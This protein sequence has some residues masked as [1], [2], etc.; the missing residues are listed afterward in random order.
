MKDNEHSVKLL[1]LLSIVLVIGFSAT[2]WISYRVSHQALRRQIIENELPLTSDNIYSEIQRDLLPPVFI[3]SLM[4]NDSFL[5]NWVISGEKNPEQL[6]QFLAETQRKYNTFTCFLVSERTRLYYQSKGILKKVT[7]DNLQDHWYFRVRKMKTDHEINIDPD[8]ANAYT[9]TIFV[10]NRVYDFDGNYIGATGVGLKVSDVKSIIENYHKKFNRIIHFISREGNI[11]LSTDGNT[12]RNI[13]DIPGLATVAPGILGNRADSFEYELDGKTFYVKTRFIPE[14]NWTLLV[15]K[16]DEH[17]LRDVFHS[18]LLNL[19]LCGLVTAIVTGL[20]YLI[21]KSHRRKLKAMLTVE[22]ELK[23]RNLEQQNE[24]DKQHRQLIEQNARLIQLNASKDKLFSIIAH[25]LRSPLGNLSQ[26]AA[27]AGEDLA[28]GDAKEA[29]VLLKHQRELADSTLKLLDHLFDWARS[30]MSEI[31]CD[32]TDFPLFECLREG[33][34]AIGL[35]AD[36]KNIAIELECAPGITVN[37]DRNMVMTVIRN[38]A[39][40]AIKFTPDGGRVEISVQA[41]G[42]T[43]TVSVKDSGVGIAPERLESIFDFVHNKS[44]PGTGGEEGTGLGL[45]LCRELVH[46]NG[47]EISV[48]S[49]PGQGS[50]FRFTLRKA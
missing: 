50:T 29:G 38:L 21:V 32:A 40:N 16:T 4:A 19:A 24:L 9:M 2:S 5:R 18:L 11:V 37:A 39:S 30:Q 31:T 28:A 12:G 8:Q 47:G 35:P 6:V 22:L 17:A 42:D 27:L 3:S 20:I 15:S 46:R 23:D 48:E 45:S 44:T 7:D 10:N 13:K 49:T 33:V 25:D 1:L 26:L 34:A 41:S 36:Q 43:V 14:L